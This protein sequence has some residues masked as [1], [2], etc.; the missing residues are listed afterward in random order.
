M[1][2][3][4]DT[5]NQVQVSVPNDH[6]KKES[7]MTKIYSMTIIY[8]ISRETEVESALHVDVAEGVC[9][10]PCIFRTVKL[11]IDYQN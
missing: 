4:L 7:K 3:R 6:N 8:V 5:E 2:V 1:Q 9:M 11:F 10:V